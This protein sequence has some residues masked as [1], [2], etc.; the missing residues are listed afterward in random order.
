MSFLYCDLQGDTFISGPL[1]QKEKILAHCDLK[2][3]E[4]YA[5]IFFQ[6]VEY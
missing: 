1:D 4:L 6:G 2:W 3:E 5:K